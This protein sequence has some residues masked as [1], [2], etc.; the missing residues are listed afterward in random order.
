MCL[1]YVTAAYFLLV[2]SGELSEAAANS[3]FYSYAH[4]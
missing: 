4:N 3:L 2:V 1:D